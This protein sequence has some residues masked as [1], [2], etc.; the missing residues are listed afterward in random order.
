MRRF[1]LPLLAVTFLAAAARGEEPA[2]AS[3]ETAAQKLQAATATVRIWDAGDKHQT[4]PASVVVCSGVCVQKGKVVTS[5]FA[6]SDSRIRLTLA[7]GTQ[8]DAKLQLIDEH[9]GLA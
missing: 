3:W 1:L 4:P 8:A 2:A 5:A 6:G 7:G 9:S